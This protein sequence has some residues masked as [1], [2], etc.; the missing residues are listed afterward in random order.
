M[1]LNAW[2]PALVVYTDNLPEGVGGR[3]NAFV[4]RLRPEYANDEGMLQHELEHVK[5]AYA[6]LLVLHPLAYRFIKAYRFWAE[7]K[8][9]ER[10]MQ[11]P[12]AD[13]TH[14]GDYEMSRCMSQPVYQFNMTVEEILD[15]V[16]QLRK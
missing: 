2:P 6:S 15:K 16:R 3:A 13:G 9:Y 14:M 7:M 5:Q 12:R 8:A 11:F 10:Q 1:K 4:V